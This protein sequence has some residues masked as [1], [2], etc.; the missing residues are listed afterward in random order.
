[1]KLQSIVK[2]LSKPEFLLDE[3]LPDIFRQTVQKFPSK[4]ALIFQEV[5][6]TYSQLNVW[7]DEIAMLLLE[8][9][10]EPG[11]KVGV[12]WSRG[13]TLHAAIL[14]I[15]KAGAGYVPLDR[16][17]PAERVERV[18]NEVGAKVYFA[19]Q[20]LNIDGLLLSVPP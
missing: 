13:A 17:M 7:S 11:D 2:G 5:H 12:W 18:L 20:I 16:E 10:I 3:T 14:G 4:I 9:G 15:S 19:E 1:M 8:N 6:L